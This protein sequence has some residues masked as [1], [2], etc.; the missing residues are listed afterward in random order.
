MNTLKIFC[1]APLTDSAMELLRE[2]VGSHE[3]VLPRRP[4]ASVL[5]KS[6]FDPAFATVDIAF[7]QPNLA[8]VRQAE[9][10]RWMQLS[11]A[12]YTRYDTQDF[13][14]WAVARG[15]VVTNSS[16]VYSEP[17]AEHVFA[18]MMAHA[19]RL[20]EAF[21]SRDWSGTAPWA[22]LRNACSSMRGQCAVILGFGSIASHLAKLLAP[23]G[24]RI[25]AMRRKP[26]GDEGVEVV[27]P[28]RL[29]EAFAVADHVVNILPENAD[30]V[31]FVN[32][33][34]IAWI[35][36]G[37]A[38]YNIGRG[39]TV[40][41]E[42]LLDALRSGHLDSAWLDVADPE[43]LPEDHP[44]LAAPNC[45]ITPHIAGGHHDEAGTQAR[46]FLANFR[47]FLDGA[48]LVDRIM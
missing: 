37:A 9:K 35:K 17:C 41:Q 29:S 5:A 34:R 44:L 16:G 39:A 40:D 23:F 7:G 21:K 48:P 3:I 31:R 15:L 45:H 28:E 30:S 8:N 46:H 32:A 1:D 12:G 36:P 42:A 33:E 19:R 2:G 47:R 43:P 4:A 22:R 10:L 13:R 26:R 20:P 27:T 14:A 24:M 11:S 6:E 18:L 38:F 25:I